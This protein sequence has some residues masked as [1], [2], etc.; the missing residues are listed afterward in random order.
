[1]K[2]IFEHPSWLHPSRLVNLLGCCRKEFFEFCEGEVFQ[3]LEAF[4]QL[5]SVV[6]DRLALDM[7]FSCDAS[8]PC[9]ALCPH[10][11]VFLLIFWVINLLLVISL[12]AVYS[13]QNLDILVSEVLVNNRRVPDILKGAVA[14][15]QPTS[16]ATCR[17]ESKT[18]SLLHTECHLH[19]CPT[20]YLHPHTSFLS[21]G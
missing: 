14:T 11:L 18:L 1:M 17:D 3:G 4:H 20:Q 5:R 16:I 6:R 8:T 21:R 13:E 19:A 10:L 7:S 12:P 9:L 15:F 2:S